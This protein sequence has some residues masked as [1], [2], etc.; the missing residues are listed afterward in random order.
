MGRYEYRP[1]ITLTILLT[2]VYILYIYSPFIHLTEITTELPNP[3][4]AQ[5]KARTVFSG[6]NTEIVGSNPTRG[7]EVVSCVYV[8]LIG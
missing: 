6:S 7:T 5:S 1:V 3:V 4:V 2:L 8:V